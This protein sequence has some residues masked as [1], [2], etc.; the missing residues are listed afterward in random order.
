MEP[1][2]ELGLAKL[3][4]KLLADTILQINKHVFGPKRHNTLCKVETDSSMEV[5]AVA[6]ALE[7]SA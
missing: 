6:V 4:G 1:F 7:H 2:T 5:V 3:Q